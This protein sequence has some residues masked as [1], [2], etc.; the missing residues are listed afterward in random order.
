M[1]KRKRLL[2]KGADT[3]RKEHHGEGVD[4]SGAGGGAMKK[5]SAKCPH[6]R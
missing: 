1:E 4:G 6:N 3:A 2:S 5:G